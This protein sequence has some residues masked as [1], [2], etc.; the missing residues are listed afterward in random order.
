VAHVR[1]EPPADLRLV[2][3]I[4]ELSMPTDET[5]KRL[6]EQFS[7]NQAVHNIGR[8]AML[9]AALSQRRYELL[10]V[11]TEDVLHQPARGTIFKPM[12]PIFQAA[13]DSGALGVFLSG[14]GPTIAALAT[15]RFEDIAGAMRE[16]AAAHGV[17]STS[18]VCA[19]SGAGAAL[20]E[21]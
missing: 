1:V 21:E 13:R 5:R 17:A 4:P 20:V 9:V 11:A 7:R 16:I 6:P 14:G 2:L 3:L 18:R 10:S 15:D 12:Y 8:A 19:L